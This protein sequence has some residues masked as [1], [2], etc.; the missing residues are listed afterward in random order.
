MAPINRLI[1][2]VPFDMHC[3]RWQV[4]LEHSISEQKSYMTYF[5]VEWYN[6]SHLNN[7]ALPTPSLDWHPS[8]HI[9]F[10]DTVH[11]RKLHTDSPVRVMICG[12]YVVHFI[13]ESMMILAGN[14]Y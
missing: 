7:L 9:S 1:D 11:L 4:F 3:Y 6:P 5:S 14:K 13:I 8:D 12:R 2:T 10:V